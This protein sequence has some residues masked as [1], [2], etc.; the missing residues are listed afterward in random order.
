MKY[1]YSEELQRMISAVDELIQATYDAELKP[2]IV[3]SILRIS[4]AN[5]RAKKRIEPLKEYKKMLLE[6][7]K[8]IGI[9]LTIQEAIDLGIYKEDDINGNTKH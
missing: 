3:T 6:E 7:M 5:E 2:N 1:I 9:E 8:P 4:E